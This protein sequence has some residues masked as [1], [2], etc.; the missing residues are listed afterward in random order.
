MVSLKMEL[1]NSL[2][3]TNQV[4][5]QY[6]MAELPICPNERAIQYC[7]KISIVHYIYI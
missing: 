4:C 5:G 7:T 6:K 1:A 3:G 2:V